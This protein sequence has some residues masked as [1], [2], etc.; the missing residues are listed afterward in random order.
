MERFNNYKQNSVCTDYNK[1]ILIDR[2]AFEII[3]QRFSFD[4]KKS[5]LCTHFAPLKLIYA[6]NQSFKIS[7]RYI[8]SKS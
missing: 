8:V 5:S 3:M 2:R 6:P 4:F 1:M 7:N